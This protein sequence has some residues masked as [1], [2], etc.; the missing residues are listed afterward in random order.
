M[1]KAIVL[2]MLLCILVGCQEEQTSDLS[3][4]LLTL[5]PE[6]QAKW[7]EKYGDGFESQQTANLVLAIQTINRQ[8][9]AIQELDKR[10]VKLEKIADPNETGESK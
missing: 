5:R 3:E 10:L 6:D 1:K 8:G 9:Q 2:S 7:N 4:Q